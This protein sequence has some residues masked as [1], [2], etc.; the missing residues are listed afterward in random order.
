MSSLAG[1]GGGCR[2]RVIVMR[3]I[4]AS[5]WSEHVGVSWPALTT[6]NGHP[7]E[8]VEMSEN[9]ATAAATRKTAGPRRA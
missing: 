5:W 3:G 8:E 2:L 7:G 1:G 9:R 6:R 4:F